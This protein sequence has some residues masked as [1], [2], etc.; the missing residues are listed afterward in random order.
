MINQFTIKNYRLFQSEAMLDFFPAPI[1][2]HKASLLT[3]PDDQ[4][5]FLPVLSIYG[6]NG[7]GKSSLLEALSLVCGFALGN[8]RLSENLSGV[9]CLLEPSTRTDPLS[10]DLLFRHHGYL[11][12]YQLIFSGRTISDETLFYGNLSSDDA[13]IIFSRKSKGIHLGKEAGE[14][15]LSPKTP[16]SSL[17]PV[18]AERSDSECVKAAWDWFSSVRFY[19][20]TDFT[21]IPLLPEEDRARGEICRL[22]Q[23]MGLDIRD[24]RTGSGLTLL[25]GKPGEPTVS[26]PFSAESS[27]TKK[28]LHLL[29]RVRESLESGSLLLADDL[30]S[31]L[32]PHLLR[33]LI[34][35]YKN[36]HRNPNGAQLIFT[37]HDTEIMTPSLM[38]RDEIFLCSRPDGRGAILYPL[39]SYKK[40]NGLIPRNDEAYGKQYLEGRYGASPLILSETAWNTSGNHLKV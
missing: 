34:S 7:G 10:F 20:G 28:L 31:V 8:D 16:L 30:D 2:E 26:I 18:V 32:H 38:R 15:L 22:L 33:F 3:D 23:D 27:G 13:G 25:H 11:F 19:N 39:S 17:L 40:R 12:R 6:P 14:F 24:Y 36:P 5:S 29:P 35:L 1:Q 21:Q 4:E 9:V 37:G